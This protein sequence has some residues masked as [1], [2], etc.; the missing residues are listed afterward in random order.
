MKIPPQSSD[1]FLVLGSYSVLDA[2][3]LLRAFDKANVQYEVELDDGSTKIDPISS[4]LGGKFGQ[5]AQATIRVAQSSK[6]VAEKV[7]ADVFGDCLPNYEA[8]F[9]KRDQTD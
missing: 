1:D 4:A 8:T 5:A 3:R 6:D 9:F 7:H 2:E